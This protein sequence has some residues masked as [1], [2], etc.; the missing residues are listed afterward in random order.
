MQL[1]ST[2]AFTRLGTWRLL[3]M[4]QSRMHD[5][6]PMDVM[7]VTA[8]G[9]SP[10][11]AAS[12]SASAW[13][14]ATKHAVLRLH[15]AA[16]SGFRPS[17]ACFCS[18]CC[19]D[20]SQASRS[21][22]Q[23]HEQTGIAYRKSGRQVR[24]QLP[25]RSHVPCRRTAKALVRQTPHAKPQTTFHHDEGTTAVQHAILHSCCLLVLCRHCLLKL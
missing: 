18:S 1:D 9:C 4:S 13:D 17:L 3:C 23:H 8:S 5:T 25:T 15:R 11:R 20:S 21:C 16:S 24:P 7:T 22:V 10:P 19:Q 2:N 12:S 14:G 6:F